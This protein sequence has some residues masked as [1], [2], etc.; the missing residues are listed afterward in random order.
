M[1]TKAH[2]PGI[3]HLQ[4]PCALLL[5]IVFVII[6]VFSIMFTCCE[7]QVGSHPREFAAHHPHGSAHVSVYEPWVESSVVFLVY[8]IL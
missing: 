5:L 7:T 4:L 3:S 8:Q 1:T 6:V 2:T